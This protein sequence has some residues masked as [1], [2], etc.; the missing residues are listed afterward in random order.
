MRRALPWVL[1]IIFLVGF[2]AS[3]AE[4]Q[5]MRNRF[6]EMSQHAFHDHAAVRE[7]MIRAAL[8]DAP[9]PIVVLGDS[10]TEMAP[11]PRQL[12]GRP[13]INAG[14]GGQTIREAKQLAR[15]LLD[16][17]DAFL[18]VLAV[19]ANDAGSPKA[20]RDF[21]DLVETVKPLSMR[22][23]VAIAVAAD[24]VTNQAIEA[25]AVAGGIRL[26][27]PLLPPGAKMPDGIHFT[28]AGYGAW[29]PA[30]EAAISAECTM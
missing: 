22:P 8:A 3:F 29:V 4:L 12:C 27:D 6:G 7:F 13:I 9:A 5:R 1:A 2:V 11:L 17:Q 19:G 16:D 30:L 21:A 20:Q 24:A 18:L 25:S 26:I 14:V 10:V 28:A 15:R 23:L